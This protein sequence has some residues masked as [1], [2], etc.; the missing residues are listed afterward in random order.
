M[1]DS[2][3]SE[4]TVGSPMRETPSATSEQPILA[5]APAT[6]AE[7][8]SAQEETQEDES[9]RKRAT[10]A[11]LRAG[12]A[13]GFGMFN[14]GPASPSAAEDP[15]QLDAE[16]AVAAAPPFVEEDDTELAPPIPRTP[17]GPPTTQPPTSDDEEDEAPPPPPPG[18]PPVPVS[19]PSVP[20]I[21]TSIPN[22]PTKQVQSPMD[23]SASP[24]TPIRTPSFGTRPPVPSA[25]KR[26]SVGPSGTRQIPQNSIPEGRVASQSPA[27]GSWQLADEPAVMAMDQ[28]FSSPPPQ[29][30]RQLPPIQTTSAAPVTGPQTPASP[31]RS[32]SSVSRTSMDQSQMSAGVAGMSPASRQA[33]RQSTDP[34]PSFSTG[35]PGFSELQEAAN[36]HGQKLARAARGMFEQGKKGY[37]GVRVSSSDRI[38]LL[39]KPIV[40]W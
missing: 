33:S 8:S 19:R 38:Y 30:I 1:P 37:Y 13:L 31:R 5:S 9:T 35:R 27:G 22:T 18:R 34:R 20:I 15:R 7:G 26:M 21:A 3:G 36:N 40:G 12:G 16:S 2:A 24:S 14:H 10:L 11:R 32:L 25:E 28:D 29:P 23:Q 6:E 4:E 17:A 39:T